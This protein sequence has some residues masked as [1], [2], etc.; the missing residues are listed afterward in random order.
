MAKNPVLHGQAK[1]IDIR[2]HIIR[3]AVMNKVA[4]L[5]YCKSE[6]MIADL[7]TKALPKPRFLKIHA[8]LGLE[9]MPLEHT[10]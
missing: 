6:N 4:V 10:N 9:P 7:F 2:Y 8:R 3:E 1:P 5:E